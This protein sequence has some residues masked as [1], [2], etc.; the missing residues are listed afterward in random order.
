MARAADRNANLLDA[1]GDGRSA[2]AV[3]VEPELIARDFRAAADHFIAIEK[4]PIGPVRK[5]IA[6]VTGQRVRGLMQSD[7]DG[8]DPMAIVAA[9]RNCTKSREAVERI[10]QLRT[11]LS[12]PQIS[13]AVP[14]LDE[15]PL[16]GEVRDWADGMRQDLEGVAR[17]SL[18]ISGVRFGVLEGPPGTGKS[19]LG[20]ALAK[21]S[22]WQFH[23]TSV[24][25]W[26]NAGDG[27]LGGVTR[28]ATEFFDGLATGGNVIG[29]LDELQSIPDRASLEKRAREWWTPV[30][31]NV[32]IQ[33]DRVRKSGRNI[34]LLGACNHYDFLDSALIRG[35]RLETRISVRPP[36]TAEEAREVLDFYCGARVPGDG[37]DTIANLIVGLAPANIESGVRQAEALARRAGRDLTVDDLLAGFGL[38]V[39]DTPDA[40]W[41]IAV[42]E[43]AHAVLA[44]RLG[45]E[46]ISASIL[47]NDGSKGAVATDWGD[48]PITRDRLEAM[49]KVGLAGRAA[50][51]LLGSG[52]SAGARSDLVHAS[53]L[54]TSG[55]YEMGLYDRLGVSTGLGKVHD[56][57]WLEDQLSRLMEE[58][59]QL[60]REN[61]EVIEQLAEALI[62]KKLLRAKDLMAFMGAKP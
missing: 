6:E 21:S 53:G 2:I 36:N 43:A 46:I 25:G 55:R 41:P 24:G 8:L 39:P 27:H 18:P 44:L 1:L 58:V 59:R 45:A 9:I 47:P 37:L 26:F 17:G 56:D 28:A 31:D 57:Q 22:G 5:A 15:L 7:I 42:H 54:L 61:R 33:I 29:F 11:R 10:R 14:G 3:A 30:V 23:S 4:L 48:T 20:E 13:A 62:T 51:E 40:L 32:L 60:V 49:V 35:G 16:V 38:E 34:L 12:A 52:P 50:D 19:L